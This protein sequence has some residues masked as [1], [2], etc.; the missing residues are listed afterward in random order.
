M[1]QR[2]VMLCSCVQFVKITAEA[3][4]FVLCPFVTRAKEKLK[5]NSEEK[6]E[7]V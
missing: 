3:W 2:K 6:Y 4:D 7:N 1:P 5:K